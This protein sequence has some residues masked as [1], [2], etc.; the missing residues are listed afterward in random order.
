MFEEKNKYWHITLLILIFGLPYFL[1]NNLC[2]DDN[3]R[4]LT[5]WGWG[6]DGRPVANIIYYIFNNF[7]RD[8]FN[9]WPASLILGMALLGISL[10]H[11]SKKNNI[12]YKIAIFSVAVV[13]SSPFLLENYQYH[14]DGITML[15]AMTLFIDAC[16]PLGNNKK[17]VVFKVVLLTAALL[18][19]QGYISLFPIFSLIA[20]IKWRNKNCVYACRELI[21]NFITFF[22]SIVLYFVY[23]KFYSELSEWAMQANE[24]INPFI[25]KDIV[26]NNF[27]GILNYFYLLFL[28]NFGIVSFITIL[29]YVILSIKER[30]NMIN[31]AVLS[32]SI[33]LLFF[34]YFFL[35]N[36]HIGPRTF[37]SAIGIYLLVIYTFPNILNL[38][39]ILFSFIIL[40]SYIFC[41][42]I[43]SAQLQQYRFD[44]NL[45]EQVITQYDLRKGD[46]IFIQRTEWIYA[47][48][49][50]VI[51]HNLPISKF[52]IFTTFWP[53]YLLGQLGFEAKLAE[54]YKKESKEIKLKGKF[55]FKSRYFDLYLYDRK[56]LFVMHS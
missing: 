23:I 14:F 25:N 31:V 37:S 21:K 22:V 30:K 34:P 41:C 24:N 47:P 35:K 44:K 28:T 29:V 5:G 11:F 45:A 49:N 15:I 16:L 33:I 46:Q 43:N 18:T 1:I 17:S 53:K 36:V 6:G 54:N 7:S 42:S 10:L 51:M 50:K 19:Y 2:Q 39:Y 32:I 48:S 27:H 8:F 55:I 56:Y 13:F 4:V 9:F 12:E 38:K 40:F 3:Y 26:I 20:F 52:Y